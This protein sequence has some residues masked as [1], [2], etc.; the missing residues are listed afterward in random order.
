MVTAGV[1]AGLLGGL[2][3]IRVPVI[4]RVVM[5]LCCDIMKTLMVAV[6]GMACGRGGVRATRCRRKCRQTLHRQGQQQQPDGD[7][8]QRFH[9]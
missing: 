4:R 8:A 7:Q 5:C 2:A 6:H 3:I 1:T 9:R